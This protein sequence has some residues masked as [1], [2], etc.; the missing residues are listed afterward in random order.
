MPIDLASAIRGA[1]DAIG[2]AWKK[3]KRLLGTHF[4]TL[5]RT[6]ENVDQ[7]DR[8]SPT[9]TWQVVSGYERIEAMIVVAKASIEDSGHTRQG[10]RTGKI[11]TTTSL[12]TLG[13]D[14]RFLYND[15]LIGSRY[16]YCTPERNLAQMGELWAVGIEEYP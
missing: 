3:A 5:E 11:L 9:T 14:Y 8:G 15:P 10:R 6:A 1:H 13:P 2:D 7:G 16:L 12:P 4:V